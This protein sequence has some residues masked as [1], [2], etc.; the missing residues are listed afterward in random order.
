MQGPEI[1]TLTTDELAFFRLTCDLFPNGE[2]PLRFLADDEQEPADCE[3]LF[4]SLR[5]RGLLN[6]DGSGAAQHVLDRLA[7]VSECHARINLA[8]QRDGRAPRD[9]FLA[10]GV[11]VEYRRDAE[12]HSFGAARSEAALTAELAQ[13]FHTA[14]APRTPSLRLSAG[15]YLVFAVFARDLRAAPVDQPAGDAPM[16]LDEVLAYFD[17]PETKVV[18]TPSDDSWRA[19]V[20]SLAEQGVLV[21]SGDGHALHAD[22]HPLARQIVADRQ[23]TIS[24]FD[25]LDEQWLVREVSIYP[26]EAG[27]YRLGTEPDGAVVLQ[28]LSTSTLADVLGNVVSTLPNLLT[29]DAPPTLKNP[30]LAAHALKRR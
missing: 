13:L 7:P 21:S 29:A 17:E 14:P 15:D 19:S 3:S 16:S 2:S 24:R 28:E 23:H 8:A 4:V 12:Q 5:E 10:G 20:A 26:T 27:V 25:F 22:W 1:L 30:Q 9:F 11:G 6:A 18:R